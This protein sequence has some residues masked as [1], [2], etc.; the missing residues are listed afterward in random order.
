M[1]RRILFL[2]FIF[3]CLNVNSQTGERFNYEQTPNGNQIIS[4]KSEKPVSKDARVVLGHPLDKQWFNNNYVSIIEK[5]I[6]LQKRNYLTDIR[7]G[8]VSVLYSLTGKVLQVRFYQIKSNI[9]ILSEDDLWA[10]FSNLQNFEMDM[11]KFQIE[12][13][14]NWI[15]GTEAIWSYTFPL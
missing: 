1:K 3:I 4:L 10:L 15:Q 5:S 11:T 6:P 14:E 7:G 2:S 9:G 13:P 12:Y 8:T